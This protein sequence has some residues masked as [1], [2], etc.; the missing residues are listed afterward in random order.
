MESEIA[1]AQRRALSSLMVVVTSLLGSASASAQPAGPPPGKG[2][3]MEIDPDAPSEPPPPPPEKKEEAPLPPT[4]PNAWGVGGKDEEGKFAPQK[5]KQS[6]EAADAG[7]IDYGPKARVGVD[8]VIGFGDAFVVNSGPG[9][10]PSPFKATVASFVVGAQ[11]RFGD[12]WGLG[13][14]FPFSSGSVC[15]PL[16]QANAPTAND[17]FNT[18]AIGNAAIDVRPTFAISPKLKIPVAVSFYLPLAQGDYFADPTQRGAIAQAI[19]NQAAAASRGWEDNALFASKRWGIGPSVG[20][21][22]DF[23]GADK[24]AH[25]ALGT[26][27]EIM[28]RAGGTDA[29]APFQLASVL[30]DW[31]T[32]ASFFYD[33]LG[34]KLTPGLRAW[35]AVASQP[36]SRETINPNGAQFV[37]E[38][39]VMGKLPLGKD[40]KLA[41]GI[42]YVKPIAGPIGGRDGA[43]MS[44][45]RIKAEL[46]F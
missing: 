1:M 3:D 43:S 22:Y 23:A 42:G 34:G 7:A 28:P 32:G 46:Q 24:P 15:G 16:C 14:R 26:K 20:V 21:T 38:P 39:D 25:F 8:A 10:A 18:F 31:V 40:A 9:S 5:K 44:G 11:Y 17:K 45:L 37:L 6:E 13:I 41:A 12:I 33:F 27:V 36:V 35:L 2:T 4:E 30:T 19:V 29:A